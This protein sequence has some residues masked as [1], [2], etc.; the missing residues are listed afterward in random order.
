MVHTRRRPA[1]RARQ[2]GNTDGGG[3]QPE[4]CN[5]SREDSRFRLPPT[6]PQPSEYFG[7]PRLRHAPGAREHNYGWLAATGP[8]VASVGSWFGE[9][10]TG[11]ALWILR[12]HG[13]HTGDSHF[14]LRLS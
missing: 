2:P 9:E 10:P 4:A 14:R 13:G 12:S 1:A 11:L 8:D 7:P 6:T 3:S 5:R